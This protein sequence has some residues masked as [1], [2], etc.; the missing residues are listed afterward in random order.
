MPGSPPHHI[1]SRDFC[2]GERLLL[3][4]LALDSLRESGD[5]GILLLDRLLD[6]GLALLLRRGVVAIGSSLIVVGVLGLLGT[7]AWSGLGFRG[8]GGHCEVLE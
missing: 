7:L 4:I 2:S 5:G 8:L 1:I 6:R 3:H